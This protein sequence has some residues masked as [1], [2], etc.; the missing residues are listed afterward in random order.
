MFKRHT[1]SPLTAIVIGGFA[2]AV[3]TLAMDL[4]LYARQRPDNPKQRFW[5]YETGADIEDWSDVSAPGKIGHRIANTLLRKPLPPEA[6]RRDEQRDALGIR[7]HVGRAV[8]RVQRHVPHAGADHRTAVRPARLRH[9]LRDPA[10]DRRVQADHR[11]RPGD[12]DERRQRTRRLRRRD[13]PCVS[14]ADP[15][16]PAPDEVAPP[17]APESRLREFSTGRDTKYVTAWH[18]S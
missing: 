11:I 8:R 9:R 5:D 13:R 1:T 16:G 17:E 4:V 14:C 12:P 7:D 15:A 2:G 10:A 18:G 6:A 3:G